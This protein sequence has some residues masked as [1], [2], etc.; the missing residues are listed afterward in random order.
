MA[1]GLGPGC[2]AA[3]LG[4]TPPGGAGQ[5]SAG[6]STPAHCSDSSWERGG[7]HCSSSSGTG[8]S[9]GAL[10]W[11]SAH[12]SDSSCERGGLHW[13]WSVGCVAALTRVLAVAVSPV[14]E[15]VI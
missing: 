1:M 13:S 14:P 11:S 4:Y 10:P 7:L 15:S 3:V 2:Q 5:D 8:V 9:W 6:Q 12:C